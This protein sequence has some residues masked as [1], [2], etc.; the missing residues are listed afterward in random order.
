MT[1]IYD[2]REVFYNE[3]G[4]FVN[5][6]DSVTIVTALNHFLEEPD[7]LEGDEPTRWPGAFICSRNVTVRKMHFYVSGHYYLRYYS[8]LTFRKIDSFTDTSAHPGQSFKPYIY[9]HSTYSQE[10]P[11]IMN[12]TYSFTYGASSNYD[13]STLKITPSNLIKE[14]EGGIVFR[15]NYITN[16]E[17]YEVF[18][19]EE[20]QLSDPQ[21][22]IQNGST[23][24]PE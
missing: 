22:N 12:R 11:F 16:R 14:G 13:F 20:G 2:G 1:S 18:T 8:S 21:T 3:D 15:H 24:K 4:T 6:N 5:Q 17:L 9:S 23:L 7:C 19:Y 10:V